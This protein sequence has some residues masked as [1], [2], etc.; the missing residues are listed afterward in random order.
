V[1]PI[2]LQQMRKRI[3]DENGWRMGEVNK[4]QASLVSSV[5]VEFLT[6]WFKSPLSK[7]LPRMDDFIILVLIAII[8]QFEQILENSRSLRIFGLKSHLN[9]RF[10]S[11]DS[12]ALRK[13]L[14][15]C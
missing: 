1:L 14:S 10:L 7:A 4:G 3:I 9:G 6:R 12:I 5:S 13:V 8:L 15:S 11:G 2:I